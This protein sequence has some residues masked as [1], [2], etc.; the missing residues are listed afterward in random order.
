MHAVTVVDGAVEWREHAD[1]VAGA[2]ELL[3]QVRAAGINS[4]DL[5]QR[6]GFYPAPPRSPADIPGLE[7]AGE[8]VAVGPGVLRYSVGDR[9]MAVVGGGGQGERCVVHERCALPVPNGLSWAEA[10]GFPE[11]F[12]TAHDAVF[13]QCGLS[14]GERLCVHGAAGGVGVAGVQL[15]AAAGATV[16]ATVRNPDLRGAVAELGGGSSGT[17]EVVEPEGFGAHGPFDV[18]LELIGASNVPEDVEALATGGRIAIIGVGGGGAKAELNLLGLMAKRGRIHGSTLRPRPLEGK[19]AAAAAVERHVL[20]LLASGR[21]R[22]PVSATFPMSDPTAAY[23]AFK[24]GGKLGKLV[25][26]TD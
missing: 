3:V 7:M 4:G 24:A 13:T 23:E 15:G 21:V 19:A 8:V 5:L 2:G 14:I 20:P 17:V 25:L 26:V 12:T 22:V 9:V 6:A 1:P 10:A 18:V 11:A 16:V